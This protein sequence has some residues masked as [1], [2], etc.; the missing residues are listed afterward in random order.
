MDDFVNNKDVIKLLESEPELIMLAET[1][2]SISYLAGISEDFLFRNYQQGIIKGTL[3]PA[4]ALSTDD[5][6]TYLSMVSKAIIQML[7]AGQPAELIH[8][9]ERALLT[10]ADTLNSKIMSVSESVFDLK[11]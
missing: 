1:L 7:Q 6:E 5:K 3:R 8:P 4:K 9:Q 2:E 11:G 10:E